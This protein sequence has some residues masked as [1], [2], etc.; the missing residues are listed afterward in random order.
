MTSSPIDPASWVVIAP[1]PA[2]FFQIN[3]GLVALGP[4]DPTL[5]FTLAENGTPLNFQSVPEPATLALVGSGLAALA[6]LRKRRK[7]SHN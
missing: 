2:Q 4:P 6:G 5:G 1:G 7:K 3:F